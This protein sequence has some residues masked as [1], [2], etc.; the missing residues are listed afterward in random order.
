M[1]H[2]ENCPVCNL[3]NSRAYLSC[4]D[5]SVSK[6]SF[7]LL[8]CDSCGLIYTNPRPSIQGIG[9]YYDSPDY[10]SHNNTNQGL[11]H[12]LYKLIRK[13]SL[14]KKVKLVQSISHT[15]KIRILDIGCGTGDF[16]NIC[17][18]NGMDVTGVEPHE[19]AR[20]LAINRFG[21]N[22]YT[23]SVFY[24][25][26]WIGRFNVISLWHVL[27]HVHNLQ[28]RLEQVNTFLIRDGVVI[29]ALPNPTSYDAAFYKEKWAA[30]DV[31]RHLY[32]FKPHVIKN[33]MQ[34]K[35]F[36]F[37]K[38]LPMPF[39]SFYVSM[40]SEKHQGSKLGLLNAFY[41]GLKSNFK[42]MGNPEK[43]SSTIYIFKKN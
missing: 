40:L 42:A 26:D 18:L 37:I 39:D 10:I 9:P 20:Q 33:L 43:Y 4:K 16:L 27:E 36:R 13:Y 34:N 35:G 6:E 14:R 12:K 29:L 1:E 7:R 41:L 19:G 28:E 3:S 2:L 30:Y 24:K 17:Q 5:Y 32:H 15:D 23:D 25:N 31:P 8:L 21:L 38:S 11:I 22:I